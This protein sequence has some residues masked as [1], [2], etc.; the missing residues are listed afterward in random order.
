[1]MLV[2]PF[3]GDKQMGVMNWLGGIFKPHDSTQP[4]GTSRNPYVG[5]TD[6]EKLRSGPSGVILPYFLPYLDQL[7]NV[8]ETAVMRHAYRRMLADPNVKAPLVA[9]IFGVS[10]LEL[11]INPSPKDDER[12][13]TMA[14]F[15][16]WNL[17]RRLADGFPGMCWSILSGGLMDGFS[18]SEKVRG[19]Q[20]KGKWKGKNVLRQ[21]KAKDVDQDLVLQ[22][23]EFR[24]ITGIMGLRYNP[25]V[26]FSPKDFI[27]F[28]HLPLFDSPVG[29]SDLRAA[30][31][32]YWILDTVIKLRAMGAEKRALPLVWGSY[33]DST[34]LPAL[35][36]AL[37]AVKSQTWLAVPE[38]VKLQC[39][40]IAGAANDYFASF[41]SDLR[42]E[43][44]LSIEGATMQAM[45]A[46]PG[47]ERGNSNTAKDT[48]DLRK[49]FL[50][51]CIIQLLND[52]E[53]GLIRE[54]C[55]L[56]FADVEEYPYATMAGV[57]DAELGET[58]K[59]DQGLQ[60]M[61]FKHKIEDIAERYGRQ[62]ATD[63]DEPLVSIQEQ[64]AE[65]ARAAGNVPGLPAPNAKL[66]KKGEDLGADKFAEN[67]GQYGKYVVKQVDAEALRNT[68]LEAEEFGN[69][70]TRLQFGFIPV[71]HIWVDKDATANDKRYFIANG[72][73]QLKAK[74]SGMSDDDAYDAALKKER[75]E[76]E[77]A[78]GLPKASE[79]EMRH[80][81]IVPDG[82]RIRLLKT[83]GQG[84]GIW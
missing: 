78:N 51:A 5:S 10:S 80:R 68:S 58:L 66:A 23:D 28:R 6:K 60:Q 42:E 33:T 38:S 1:M 70:A 84:Q 75:S 52:Y 63:E 55:D 22:A 8:G 56:N 48:A 27:I 24:N 19:I 71:N 45:P 18:V 4:E 79:R 44:V 7:Q 62:P 40:E 11:R 54:L 17:T 20:D 12:C 41:C 16:H 65:Q 74:E 25:G 72:I 61:G 26:V 3:T 47:V 64:Q 67:Y 46:A 21:V 15:C 2:E 43:I 83:I 39:L 14:D 37:A 9:K 13:K 50:S 81:D 29:M 49:W 36:R 35:E 57:D 53:N 77:K 31:G 76:R 30:Y 32:R 69:V 82:V 59:L 34:K 73:A